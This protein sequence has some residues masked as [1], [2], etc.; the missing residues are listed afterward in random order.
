MEKYSLTENLFNTDIK[1]TGDELDPWN[2]ESEKE[3][4]IVGGD[5]FVRFYGKN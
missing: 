5:K 4:F 2:M 1:M 3:L